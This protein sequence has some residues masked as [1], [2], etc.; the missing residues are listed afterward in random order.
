VAEAERQVAAERAERAERKRRA[1][2][3][4]AAAERR[5]ADERAAAERAER[6]REA[7]MEALSISMAPDVPDTEIAV[8]PAATMVKV[9][10]FERE[11][12]LVPVGF[13][14]TAAAVPAKSERSAATGLAAPAPEAGPVPS[15]PGVKV[16]A[17]IVAILVR[18]LGAIDRAVTS[19]VRAFRRPAAA[20]P[21][22]SEAP[23]GAPFAAPVGVITPAAAP[24]RA[25][26][27][28][29]VQPVAPPPASALPP[30]AAPP[31]A[32]WDATAVKSV[33]PAAAPREAPRKPAM[34]PPTFQKLEVIPFAAAPAETR[35]T[36]DMWEGEEPSWEEPGPIASAFA[37]GWRWVKRIV[38]TGALVAG[39]VL[40]A[41]NREKWIPQ[42]QDAATTLGQ[43]VDRLSRSSRDVPSREIEEAREQIPYLRPTTIEMVLAKSPVPIDVAETF[44]RAHEAVERARPSLPANVAAEID[45]LTAAV[46]AE[47]EPAERARVVSY[48]GAIRAGTPTAAYQDKEAIWLMARGA[49]RLPADKRSRM[50]ELFAH[51]VAAGLQPAT[52]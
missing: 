25:T 32:P 38:V 5:A 13:D 41:L 39:A 1:D 34:P 52:P 23:V 40:L 33:P 9:E 12:G 10:D 19:V 18:V 14:S 15:P 49:R 6:E 37:T 4:R 47:L 45:N 30:W 2:E 22:P 50:E 48:L 28:T 43:N 17:A 8:E 29:P 20:P 27:A 3:E 36:D 11:L 21:P 44:R 35:P 46:V 16:P 31:P 24:V 42:A 7:A 26:A 51:A